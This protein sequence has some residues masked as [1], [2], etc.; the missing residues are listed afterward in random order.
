MR[1]GTRLGDLLDTRDPLVTVAVHDPLTARVVERTGEFD[2]I[3]LSG[4]GASLSRAGLPDM[5]LLTM[6]EM[7][8]HARNVQERID[9][10]LV[11]DGDDGYGGPANVVR[12]IREFAAAG[13]GGVLLEDQARP[14]RHG[15]DADKRVIPRERA[16]GRL[17]VALEA[18]DDRDPS[19]HVIGRTDALDA[20]NGSVD[21]AIA[22]ANAFGDAGA[23]L[24]YVQGP[25]SME[26]VRRV[27]EEVE[28][29][30]MYEG[31]GSSPRLGVEETASLGFDLLHYARGVTFATVLA[32]EAYAED[33]AAEGTPAFEELEETFEE[34][35][36]DLQEL[37]GRAE[38]RGIERAAEG[39]GGKR[40]NQPDG[41][42]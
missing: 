30:Q 39:E 26:E 20:E 32:V 18:R 15:Y 25:R 2:A 23:D 34:S 8:S 7:V 19:L 27:A 21:E 40:Q 13:V 36:V 12:T 11:V 9:L 4:S 28:Y 5:G 3:L 16:V 42:E 29:P 6:S 37:A 31:A 24:V 41:P 33:L 10:P 35:Y 17:R 22:R 38:F 14:K 1:N